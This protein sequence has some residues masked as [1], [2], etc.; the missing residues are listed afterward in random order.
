MPRYFLTYSA[1]VDS[2]VVTGRAYATSSHP[3]VT[4]AVVTQMEQ[5][6]LTDLRKEQPSARRLFLTWWQE[7][8]D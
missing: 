3:L 1:Q 6:I 7:L 8:K 4:E 5:D 2:G